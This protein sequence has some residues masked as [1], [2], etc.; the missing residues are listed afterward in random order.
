MPHNTGVWPLGFDQ[1]LAGVE[2]EHDIAKRV[3]AIRST[4][5]HMVPAEDDVQLS[6]N[7]RILETFSSLLSCCRQRFEATVTQ[8]G[9]R[10]NRTVKTCN[11]PVIRA[12]GD[13]LRRV[14]AKSGI[15]CFDHPRAWCMDFLD[16]QKCNFSHARLNQTSFYCAELGQS[17]FTSAN[18]EGADLTGADLTGADLSHV[19][20]SGAE[21]SGSN[22]A[23]ADLSDAEMQGVFIN[24]ANLSGAILDHATLNGAFLSGSNMIKTSLIGTDLGGANMFAT[25][26]CEAR[27]KNAILTGTGITRERI[28]RLGEIVQWNAGTMW[29][30]KDDC[31]GRNPLH[32][33]YYKTS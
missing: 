7:L 13:V 18:L 24:N 14:L 33:G 21:L 9:S 11:D 5:Y 3:M 25:R 2:Q 19:T 4:R 30:C 29:G 17:N 1:A 12:I 10:K 31:D 22:I 32:Y 28:H 8:S 23:W 6:R 20:L 26:L 15:G 16:L 27:L